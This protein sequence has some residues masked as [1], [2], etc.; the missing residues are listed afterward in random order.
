MK[1]PFQQIIKNVQGST[2]L[3]QSRK[4]NIYPVIISDFVRIK[5]SQFLKV[6]AIGIVKRINGKYYL[7]DVK[8]SNYEENTHIPTEDMGYDY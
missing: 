1:K 8:S 3:V 7:I 2:A 6:G 4:G 5:K